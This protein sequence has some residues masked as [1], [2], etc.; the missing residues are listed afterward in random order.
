MYMYV[1]TTVTCVVADESQPNLYRGMYRSE[2]Q[3][4]IR[5]LLTS[6]CFVADESQPNLHRGMYRSELQDF[7][8]Q[9]LT[10]WNVQDMY[11]D[12]TIDAVEFQYTYWPDPE[13]RTAR[14]Q[15]FIHVSVVDGILQD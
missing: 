9:L 2:L 11:I 15:E 5:Q 8:R 12:R 14:Q 1:I 13:N 3:D 10:D 6:L 4:F 7:I